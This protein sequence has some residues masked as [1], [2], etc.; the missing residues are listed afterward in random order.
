MDKPRSQ[1]KQ[2]FKNYLNQGY[3]AHFLSILGPFPAKRWL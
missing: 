3:L 2:N 1:T